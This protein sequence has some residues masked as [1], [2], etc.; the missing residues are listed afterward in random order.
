MWTILRLHG[1]H[2][3]HIPAQLVFCISKSNICTA[4]LLL[5]HGIG[6]ASM[7]EQQK[8]HL[9]KEDKIKASSLPSG[10]SHWKEIGKLSRI[11]Q[12]G[13][14]TATTSRANGVKAVRN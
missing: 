5:P 7:D 11:H 8:M 13:V 14:K 3:D 9:S 4:V 1:V 10:A 6:L 2:V 12:L